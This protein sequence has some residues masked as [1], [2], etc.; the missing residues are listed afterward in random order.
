MKISAFTMITNPDWRQDPWRE[1]IRQAMQVFDEVIV[2]YGRK[3]DDLLLQND[4][5]IHELESKNRNALEPKLK[6]Y[7]LEWPQPEW[8]YEEL[9]IHLNFALEKCTGDWAVKFDIDTMFH[10]KDIFNIHQH[11]MHFAS[12]HFTLASFQ[13]HQF[14]LADR[15]Y[16]KGR[17]NF[18]INRK[19]RIGSKICYGYDVGRYTDLCQ[20]IIPDGSMHSFERNG[21]KTK[22]IPRG[23]SVPKERIGNTGISVMNYDYTFKT[24]DVARE[25][26]FI[27]DK[28]HASFWGASYSGV[29][30]N[31]ITRDTSFNDYLGLV[32]GRLQ[33]CIKLFKPNDHPKYIRD[34]IKNIRPEEFGSNLWG[35][36]QIPS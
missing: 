35:K 10:E 14:F 1:S 4:P 17:V 16:E 3:E 30:P 20:P 8:S 19:D 21:V 12:K 22:P 25:L 26:L 2:V 32:S 13:K 33:K 6:F 27:H 36:I 24:E 28:A 15:C 31:E 9:A 5:I 29:Q 18:A 7:Y 11:L 34:R 23:V